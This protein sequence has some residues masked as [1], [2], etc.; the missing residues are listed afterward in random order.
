[1]IPPKPADTPLVIG[2]LGGVAAGKSWIATALGDH[3]FR[4]IDADSE[5]RE[6]VRDPAILAAIGERFGAEL[7]R[8]GL[9]RTALAELVFDD[10]L[11]RK[12]LEEITHPAIRGRI[13]D[14][15]A[16]A[17][18]AGASVVLDV[19]LLLEGGLIEECDESVFVEVDQEIRQTRA[20]ARGWDDKEL[21]R[22]E[23]AQAPL[24][25]KRA[26]CRFVVTNNGDTDATHAQVAAVLAELENL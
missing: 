10:P 6:V 4:V 15:L 25:E 12:E 17:R 14:R 19:P 23:A 5:A 18:A 2:L 24:A 13:L 20:A 16:A 26:H 1:M 9:D 7:V 21:A 3:G 8:D 11:A 22:R